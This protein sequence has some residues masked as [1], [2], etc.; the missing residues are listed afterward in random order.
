MTFYVQFVITLFRAHPSCNRY[1]YA[2]PFWH[3]YMDLGMEPSPVQ[4]RASGSQQLK[5]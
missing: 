5:L 1:H 2:I 4:P 3:T